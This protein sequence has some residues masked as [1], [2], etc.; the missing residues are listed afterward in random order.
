MIEQQPLQGPLARVLEDPVT[1][2]SLAR[3]WR[4]VERRRGHVPELRV[5]V[6]WLLAGVVLAFSVTAAA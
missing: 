4:R 2:A 3:V 1:E 6:R 5:A